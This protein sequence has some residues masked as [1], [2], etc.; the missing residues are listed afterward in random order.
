MR[1]LDGITN[2]MDMSWWW[3]GRPGALRFIGSQRV[4]HDWV[5]E[6]NWTESQTP[7]HSLLHFHPQWQAQICSLHQGVYF[8][9]IDRFSL[10]CSL[11]STYKWYHM[12][13]VFRLW[14]T[15][16]SMIISRSIHA[17]CKKHY[18]ILFNVLV[19]QSCAAFCDPMDYSLPGSSV[20]GILHAEI[21][22]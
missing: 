10:C 20:H 17:A 4:R 22:E 11:D 12:V 21:L 19:A 9:F 16:F 7:D 5:T 15:S 14:L 6:Q 1:W 8:C 18:L 3:T 2:S 13:F